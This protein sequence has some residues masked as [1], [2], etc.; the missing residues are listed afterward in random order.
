MGLRNWAA[1]KK[2]NDIAR[3]YL[4]L[5]V[6][7]TIFSRT[8]LR[9][10]I[11][12]MGEILVLDVGCGEGGPVALAAKH[13]KLKVVGLDIFR[14]SLDKAKRLESYQDLILGDVR[15]LPIRDK[16]VDVA[17]SVAVLEHLEKPDGEELLSELERVS[18]RMTMISC[19]VGKWEQH[20]FGNNPYQEHKYIWTV[21]ELKSKG[22]QNMNGVGLKGMSGRLW[23]TL[24]RSP[25]G[26]LVGVL[27][28]L[29]TIFSY[30]V[31]DIASNVVAWKEML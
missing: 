10:H 8:K 13:N 7:R 9:A 31:P 2:M 22:F 15:Y 17:V 6:A 1:I 23:G 24:L 26:W 28:L 20:A 21:E 19:P 4:T 29:G 3:S 27:T 11:R 30:H 25:V 16:S 12:K 18:K 14:P 5:F